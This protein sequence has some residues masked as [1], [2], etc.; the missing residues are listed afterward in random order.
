MF[1]LI[2]TMRRGSA[3]GIPVA[4]ARCETIE[5]ARIGMATLFRDDRVLRAIDRTQRGSA[6]VRGMGGTVTSLP[7]ASR[8]R[9]GKAS[10]R[11]TQRTGGDDSGA[12]QPSRL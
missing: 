10:A 8:A 4:W 1:K 5:A 9:L 6:G 12:W 7:H 11:G 3:T 2:A